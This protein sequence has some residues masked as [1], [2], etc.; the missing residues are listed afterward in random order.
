MSASPLRFDDW[1]S[2]LRADELKN[3]ARLW[4]GNSQT[5]KDQAIVLIQQGLADPEKVRAA[6]AALLPWE[7]TALALLKR[8]GGVLDSNALCV[9]L[10]VTGTTPPG[11]RTA[12]SDSCTNL[13]STLV[14]RGLILKVSERDPTYLADYVSANVYADERLLA[15]AGA[16]V[17]VPFKIKPT[18]LPKSSLHRRPQAV[19]LDLIG[20]LQAVESQGGIGLTQNGGLRVNDIRRVAR[21]MRWTEDA[22]PIDGLSFPFLGA[23]LIHALRYGGILQEKA[24]VMALATPISVFTAQPYAEQIRRVLFGFVQANEWYEGG[25]PTN[26]LNTTRL[27]QAREALTVALAALPDQGDAFFAVDDLSRALFERIGEQF[28]LFRPVGLPYDYGY[29]KTAEQQQQERLAWQEKLRQEWLK[30][31]RVW[32]A[33]ALATWCYFLGIVELSFRDQEVH[34]VRLTDL[35]RAIL[36]GSPAQDK[37]APAAAARTAWVVQPNFEVVVYLDQAN[38]AQL[39]FLERHAERFHTEHHVAQYRLSRQTVYAAL[40]SGSTL[41]QMLT[42]LEHGAD[43]PLPQNVVAELREWAALREQITLYRRAQLLEFADAASRDDAMP[44]LTGVAVGERF[45]LMTA[46]SAQHLTESQVRTRVNYAAALAKCLTIDED[47]VMTAVQHPLDLLFDAQMARW[48]EPRE[49]MQ[50][51]VTQ[52][53]VS[54][55]LRAG[56]TRTELFR[57]LADRLSGPLPPL[58]EVALRAWAGEPIAVGLTGV[59]V[60]QCPQPT[61]FAAIAAS[62]TLRRFLRG[63]LAPDLLV[64]D[65]DQLE[66]FQAHLRWAGLEISPQLTVKRRRDS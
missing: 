64:I 54:A 62:P 35:G 38:P 11:A 4:G 36:H 50:W 61:V 52:A 53:S 41:E 1:L 10:R 42:T 34:A 45:L 8:A 3:M 12:Y 56:G 43:R 28:A 47:G 60:L 39:A 7:A 17:I 63:E 59:I 9:G 24:G 18:P 44:R 25:R 6:V 55:G 65:G 19:A 26:S 57:L 51:Q 5:R 31:E 27:P 48:T 30:S 40:E 37:P 66:A 23:G 21:A 14:R 58:L 13:L 32:T 2:R 49:A 15:A 46:K 29:G 20:L 22:T 16:P 33:Q